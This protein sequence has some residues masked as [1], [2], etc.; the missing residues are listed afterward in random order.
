[1]K[2]V[3]LNHPKIKTRLETMNPIPASMKAVRQHR[4]GRSLVIESVPVPVPGK[5]EVLVKMHAA[6]LNP[7]DLSLLKGGYL[8]RNYPFIPGLEGSGMVVKSGGGLIGRLRKGKWVACAP[9]P[10][11]DGTWAEYMKTSA[12]RTVPLPGGIPPEKGSMMLV[13]P[14]TAVA[15]I[16]IAK[17]RNHRA[18]VNNAAASALGK[19]LIRLA[20]QSRITLINIVRKKEQEEALKSMGAKFVLNSTEPSFE[21]EL[22]R[23]AGTLH[24]SLFLDAVGGAETPV[25][26][27]AAPPGATLLAYARLSGNQVQT[28]PGWLIQEGKRMEGFQLGRWLQEQSFFTKLRLISRV[29]KGMKETLSS[30]VR[31]VLPMDEVNQA[32]ALYKQEMSSGKIILK[33]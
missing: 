12:L 18:M 17:R 1:L 13:N 3:D 28:D 25:L 5:G 16:E 30:E 6:P 11:G 24:A 2:K 26:M 29:K 33:L 27:K 15:L 23:I 22:K 20:D 9:D 7:S 8:E 10:E 21:T 14:M 19:M 4:P 31:E 32:I